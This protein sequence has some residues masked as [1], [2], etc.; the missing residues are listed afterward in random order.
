MSWCNGL[1]SGSER[2]SNLEKQVLVLQSG[3]LREAVIFYISR[4]NHM[5]IRWVK[6]RFL[7]ASFP[8]GIMV[9]NICEGGLV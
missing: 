6:N 9:L 4:R 2:K 1:K 7:C 8:P 3:K 5:L